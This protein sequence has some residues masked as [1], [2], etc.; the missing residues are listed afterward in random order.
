MNDVVRVDGASVLISHC[1]TLQQKP[2][3]C[4]HQ[5]AEQRENGDWEEESGCGYDVK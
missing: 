3:V 5:S 2:N 4:F 1:N